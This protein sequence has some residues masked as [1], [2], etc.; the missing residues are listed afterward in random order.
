MIELEQAL[1]ERKLCNVISRVLSRTFPRIAAWTTV[2]A[3]NGFAAL[4]QT[5]T[6]PPAVTTA[7][8][9]SAEQALAQVVDQFTQAQVGFQPSSLRNLTTPDCI[10]VSHSRKETCAECFPFLTTV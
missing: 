8:P 10:E 7:V 2:L 9:S 4:A 6:P 5:S 3:L 1:M